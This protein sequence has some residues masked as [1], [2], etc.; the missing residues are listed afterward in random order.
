[1]KKTILRIVFLVIIISIMSLNFGSK[2]N[3]IIN[4][5]TESNTILRNDYISTP[6][7][8][9]FLV[10]VS[11]GDDFFEEE[12]NKRHQE[13]INKYPDVEYLSPASKFYNCHSYGWYEQDSSINNVKMTTPNPYIDDYTYE[14]VF[15]ARKGDILCYLDQV[16]GVEPVNIN[17]EN[18]SHSAIIVEVNGEYNFSDKN[19]IAAFKVKSKWGDDGVYEYNAYDCRYG[20]DNPYYVGFSIYRP[21]TTNTYTLSKTM[22][23]VEKLK[24]INLSTPII[25]KYELYELNVSET[26]FYE[27][28]IESTSSVN[29]KLY[30]ER[31]HEISEY[32]N[33]TINFYQRLDIGKRYYLRVALSSTEIAGN[34]TTQIKPSII[35]NLSVGNNTIKSHNNKYYSTTTGLYKFTLSGNTLNGSLSYNEDS[36]KIYSDS[37]K[38]NL[39]ERISTSLYELDASTSTNT[40]SLVVYLEEGNTYYIDILL[41]DEDIMSLNLNINRIYETTII[42]LNNYINDDITTYDIFSNDISKGDNFK[43]IKIHHLTNVTTSFIYNG[44]QEEDL[45]FILYKEVFSN[46]DSF[47]QLV[48]PEMLVTCKES[49]TWTGNLEEGTYYIGYYNKLNNSPISISITQ[50]IDYYNSKLLISDPDTLS[51]SGSMVNI[52]EKNSS[53]KSYRGTNIVIGF[54]RVLYIDPSLSNISRYDY[55]WYSSDEEK[56]SIS[57]HGTVLGIESGEVIIIAVNKTDPRIIQYQTFNIINDNNTSNNEVIVNINDSHSISDGI[58]QVSLTVQ[59]SPYPRALWYEWE[60]ISYDDSIS[61]VTI[62]VFGRVEIIGTGHVII[63]GSNYIYNDKYSIVINLIV[64]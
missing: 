42:D 39:L 59:N 40:N 24:Q 25:D 38:N 26:E 37:N 3:A 18:I 14:K 16:D 60:I 13:I 33:Q 58:Y 6:N 47:L 10:T 31:M 57:Y 48:Y 11:E 22:G 35:Q 28:N 56:A 5:G 7:G 21:R 34:I 54:T 20:K 62:D 51:T 46:T 41:M 23:T 2:V 45:Y 8:T 49:M 4:N 61:Y 32:N 30:D 9:S 19:S 63:K 55:N 50:N 36:I 27:F 15:D 52:Y 43:K 17:N 12:I 64:T 1:M 44:T 29:V 53:N